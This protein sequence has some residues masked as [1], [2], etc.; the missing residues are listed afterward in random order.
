MT[1][2]EKGSTEKK[3]VKLKYSRGYYCPKIQDDCNYAFIICDVCKGEV[4]YNQTHH[5]LY[6]PCT[7]PVKIEVSQAQ[8]DDQFTSI[9]GN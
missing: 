8:L 4:I 2:L 6:C 9:G 1:L 5:W 3:P 7:A